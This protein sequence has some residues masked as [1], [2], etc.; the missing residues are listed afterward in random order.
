[1]LGISGCI[2]IFR[3]RISQTK[4]FHQHYIYPEAWT[5]RKLL[6]LIALVIGAAQASDCPVDDVALLQDLGVYF[7]VQWRSVSVRKI[8][9]YKRYINPN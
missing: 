9:N 1:M 4:F 6:S 2:A 8:L 5:I 7:E 3:N